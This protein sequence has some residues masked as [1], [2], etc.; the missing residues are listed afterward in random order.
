MGLDNGHTLATMPYSEYLKTEQ[1]HAKRHA[2]ITRANYKCQ[3]CYTQ[4]HLQVHHRTYER[5]GHEKPNDLMVLCDKCH[6][7]EHGL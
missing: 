2:A 1:W 6:K 4:D 5:R 3:R 7:N